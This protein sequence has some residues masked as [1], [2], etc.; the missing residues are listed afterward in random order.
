M[1]VTVGE[2]DVGEA[3]AVVGVPVGV[4]FAANWVNWATA[5]YPEDRV[6]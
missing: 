1:A 3:I 5:V 2:I 6:D 4:T